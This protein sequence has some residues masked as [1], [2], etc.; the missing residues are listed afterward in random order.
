[1]SVPF[2]YDVFLSYNSKNKAR[3]RW[4]AERLRAAGLRVWFDDW[5]IKPGDDIYLAVERG[6][7]AA[8]AQVLCLSS[9]ALGSDWVT[10]ER[11]TVLFRDPS[12]TGRRF[13]PLLLAECELPDVL[14]RYKHIDYQEEADEAFRELLLACDPTKETETSLLFQLKLVSVATSVRRIEERY[15]FEIEIEAVNLGTRPL[16]VSGLTINVPTIR[17]KEMCQLI[18]LQNR[19]TGCR[20]PTRSDPGELISGFLPDRSFGRKPSECLLIESLLDPWQPRKHITLTSTIEVPWPRLE[21]HIRVWANKTKPDGNLAVFGDP[22][23][24]SD[25]LPDQQGIPAY[26]QSIGF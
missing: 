6:L 16:A 2:Q 23:W 7:E 8:R 20:A 9:A 12:N 11:S 5:V 14:R 10:L 13:I 17:T 15:K 1:M 26:G 21:F 22:D 24:E 18:S 4:L 25:A 19:A 3:V